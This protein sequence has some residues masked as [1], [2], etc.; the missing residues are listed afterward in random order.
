MNVLRRI[1]YVDGLMRVGRA[2]LG[3]EAMGL[4]ERNLN[5]IRYE[6]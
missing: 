5:V 6:S 1:G 3:L 2:P 4:A